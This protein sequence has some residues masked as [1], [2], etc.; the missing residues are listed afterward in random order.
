MRPYCSVK[1]GVSAILLTVTDMKIQVSSVLISQSR[2]RLKRLS[3]GSRSR[4]HQVLQN[5]QRLSN[6]SELRIDISGDEGLLHF[7]YCLESGMPEVNFFLILSRSSSR[8]KRTFFMDSEIGFKICSS[9]SQ[10]T[11]Q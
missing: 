6:L 1:L 9:L 10:S 3:S 7:K 4:S 8:K 11:Q 2:T 5:S